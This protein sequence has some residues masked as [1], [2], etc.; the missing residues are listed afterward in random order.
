MKAFFL[1]RRFTEKS[2]YEILGISPSASKQE[3]KKAYYTLARSNHPDVNG[4]Q[5][6]FV[7][8]NQAYDILSDEL[9]R[10]AYD[11]QIKKNQA[12]SQS[13][14]SSANK[15]TFSAK[16]AYTQ[17]QSEKKTNE[18]TERQTNEEKPKNSPFNNYQTQASTWSGG[19]FANKDK[20][21]SNSGGSPFDA[22][23]KMFYSAVIPTTVLVWGFITYATFFSGEPKE[24]FVKPEEVETRMP[25]RGAARDLTNI[26]L[27]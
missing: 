6:N 9:K 12:R 17:Q 27:S 3:I 13:S 2:H 1:I 11:K 21:N 7:L 5:E 22:F 16:Q 24:N 14:S 18:N 26:K 20:I 10:E 4:S 23:V 25:E 15:Y 19:N 8:I